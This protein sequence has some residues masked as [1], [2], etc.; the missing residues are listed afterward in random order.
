METHH[1]RILSGKSKYGTVH[2]G[3]GLWIIKMLDVAVTVVCASSV[4]MLAMG[5]PG[6]Y[7]SV[8]QIFIF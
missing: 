3:Q 5:E 2:E 7:F 6:G 1:G 8:F 4:T